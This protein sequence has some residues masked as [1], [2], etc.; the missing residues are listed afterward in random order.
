M[1][2][3]NNIVA[4]IRFVVNEEIRDKEQIEEKERERIVNLIEFIIEL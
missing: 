3:L 1:V 2:A 4:N